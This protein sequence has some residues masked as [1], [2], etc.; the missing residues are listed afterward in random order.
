MQRIAFRLK[1]AF[2]SCPGDKINSLFSD[3]I[4]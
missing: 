1:N 4:E 2:S 3:L